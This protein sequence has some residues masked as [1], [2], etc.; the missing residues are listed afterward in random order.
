M[1]VQLLP[2]QKL[3][4]IPDVAQRHRCAIRGLAIT[5]IVLVFSVLFFGLIPTM[6]I[7]SNTSS[8]NTIAMLWLGGVPLMT[9]VFLLVLVSSIVSLRN[10]DKWASTD[11][12]CNLMRSQPACCTKSCGGNK[13]CCARLS[14]AFIAASVFSSL[15]FVLLVA[16]LIAGCTEKI[17]SYYYSWCGTSDYSSYNYYGPQYSEAP[18]RYHSTA[19]NSICVRMSGAE[20]AGLILLVCLIATTARAA[21]LVRAIE[22][23]QADIAVLPANKMVV[24]V[25][26]GNMAMMQRTVVGH[27]CVVDEE[28]PKTETRTEQNVQSV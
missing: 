1:A 15:L 16:S 20:A 26:A 19:D 25:T 12:C 17:Y 5:S 18:A 2:F 7:I 9:I 23:E 11:A 6:A 13:Y 28:E 27:A 24:Q 4:D 22:K 21:W 8:Y 3:A 10:T 14:S